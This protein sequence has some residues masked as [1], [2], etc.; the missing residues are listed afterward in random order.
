MGGGGG[1]VG[2]EEQAIA[3]STRARDAVATYAVR[4]SGARGNYAWYVNGLYEVT[5]EV[6]GGKPVYKK[7][8]AEMWLEYHVSR[9]EWMSRPTYCKGQASNACYAYVDCDVGVLPDKAPR[10]AWHVWVNRSLKAQASVVVTPISEEEVAAEAA[11]LQAALQVACAAT[12][13][14]ARAAAVVA[15]VSKNKEREE[16]EQ[17]ACVAGS[18]PSSRHIHTHT[19]IKTHLHM[20]KRYN[21]RA[22]THRMRKKRKTHT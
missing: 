12:R 14:A 8:G 22:H 10:G 2:G 4:I 7:Q 5:D 13:A 6:S 16:E 15:E 1:A 3:A 19:N 9:G 18:S 17:G 11:A 20:H 21:T